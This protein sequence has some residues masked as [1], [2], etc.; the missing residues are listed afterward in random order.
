MTIDIKHEIRD[1]IRSKV[2]KVKGETHENLE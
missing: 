2:I 1:N